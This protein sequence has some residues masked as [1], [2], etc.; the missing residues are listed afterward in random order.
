M[1]RAVS[2]T[3]FG[4][5]KGHGHPHESPN[6]MTYPLVALAFFSPWSG[7]INIPGVTE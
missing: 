6:V 3:F 1:M 2:L 4:E 5:Y 7:W